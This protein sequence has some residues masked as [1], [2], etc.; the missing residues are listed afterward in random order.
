MLI[1]LVSRLGLVVAHCGRGNKTTEVT[2]SR[3]DPH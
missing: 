1:L 2:E 3:N